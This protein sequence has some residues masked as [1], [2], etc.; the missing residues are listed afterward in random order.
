[1]SNPIY[2]SPIFA[3]KRKFIIKSPARSKSYDTTDI[4]NSYNSSFSVN[5]SYLEYFSN[6]NIIEDNKKLAQSPLKVKK[7]SQLYQ[8]FLSRSLDKDHLPP[9]LDKLGRII[10][11]SKHSQLSHIQDQKVSK[12]FDTVEKNGQFFFRKGK[13]PA[14][15]KRNIKAE[16]EREKRSN[17]IKSIHFS[18][19]EKNIP[20]TT[21]NLVLDSYLKIQKKSEKSTFPKNANYVDDLFNQKGTSHG[22]TKKLDEKDD[23]NKLLSLVR[24]S[25]QSRIDNKE[26]VHYDVETNTITE[27]VTLNNSLYSKTYTLNEYFEIFM[28]S[29]A[30]FR[31]QNTLNNCIADMF[32]N[33]STENTMVNSFFDPQSGRVDSGWNKF[34]IAVETLGRSEEAHTKKVHLLERFTR[35]ALQEL[36]SD[37]QKKG[38]GNSGHY[39]NFFS[40]AHDTQ[41]INKDKEFLNNIHGLSGR[42]DFSQKIAK[43]LMEKHIKI[44]TNENGELNF[45]DI[46]FNFLGASAKISEKE[47]LV[48]LDGIYMDIILKQLKSPDSPIKLTSQ[49]EIHKKLGDQIELRERIEQILLTKRKDYYLHLKNELEDIREK[50]KTY[51][52]EIMTNISQTMWLKLDM[53]ESYENMAEKLKLC[54][55]HDIKC[56]MI[57]PGKT[58]GFE[59]KYGSLD[60]YSNKVRMDNYYINEAFYKV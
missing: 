58:D 21:K 29:L 48:K 40:N 1:M 15:I 44:A 25:K 11:N 31:R 5:K 23:E 26:R 6:D 10:S 7:N 20:S 43:V 39:R 55:V 56:N 60:E 16:I 50:A 35:K 42:D 17:K 38:A 8:N 22:N 3:R 2:S 14:L 28:Q 45:N 30:D 53:L 9:E 54:E 24:K 18:G 33:L 49:D 57:V 41:D 52:V 34:L 51:S 19:K 37:G 47:I 4:G 59:F 27:V 13:L 12:K 32:E 36:T 46:S